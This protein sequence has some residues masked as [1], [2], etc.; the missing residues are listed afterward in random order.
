M[1]RAALGDG[2]V[3]HPSQPVGRDH[4]LLAERVESLHQ[5]A[6]AGEQPRQ[7]VDGRLEVRVGVHGGHGV[8]EGLRFL[9]ERQLPALQ[10]LHA[11][12]QRRQLAPQVLAPQREQR[13]AL[14]G[15][16]QVGHA[17]DEAL[18]FRVDLRQR[19]LLPLRLGL[20]LG[21]AEERVDV[22]RVVLTDSQ[23]ELHVLLSDR[24]HRFLWAIDRID[25]LCR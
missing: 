11:R 19:A 17:G 18:G 22:V 23:H 14:F 20:P 15:G 25:P 21:R 24:V 6:V 2:A 9:V 3:E 5:R 1:R 4:E 16:G 10:H 7:F 8:V 13:V 12:A